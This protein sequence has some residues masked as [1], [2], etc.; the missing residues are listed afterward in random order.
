MMTM[1]NH[2]LRL[3]AVP[4][5]GLALVA[6]A[7]ATTL[8]APPVIIEG[9]R[10]QGVQPTLEES[11]QS[12]S[13]TPG[14][15]NVIDVAKGDRQQNTL[16]DALALQPGVMI[17]EFFGGNDQPRLNIRGSGIQ[18][19]PQARGIRLLRDGLPINLA[20]GS[21]VIGA[22][23]PRLA[24]HMEVYRG[25]NAVEYGGTALG[26]AINLV[27]PTGRTDPG[28]ALELSGGSFGQRLI[29]VSHGA[30]EGNRDYHI[31][32]TFSEADGFRRHNDSRRGVLGGNLG[33]AHADGGETRLYFE[34][35]DLEFDIPGP[36]NRAQLE[37]NPE[38]VNRGI[39]PT[40][41]P[42]RQAG[43]ESVG[44]N[45]LRDRPWRESRFTRA[46]VRTTTPTDAGRAEFGLGYQ[47]GDD[48][49]AS[50]TNVRESDSDDLSAQAAIEITDTG[51]GGTLN[52]GVDAALGEMTR[53]FSANEEGS[54]GRPFAKNDLTAVTTML[55]GDY[56]HPLAQHWT[57]VTAAQLIHAV[58]DVDEAF[59]TPGQR[60]RY[61][62]G[63][64]QY[65]QMQTDSAVERRQTYNGV[66]ARLGIL[67]EPG[68]H[69]AWFANLSQSYEPPTFLEILSPAGTDPTNSATPNIGP[70]V[71][72]A[73]PLDAQSAITFEAGTRGQWQDLSWDIAAYYSRLE[74]ELLTDEAFTGGFGTTSNYSDNTTR[75]GLELG[76][77]WRMADSLVQKGDQ[78]RF[79][80]AY[81]YSNFR[82]DGG[83]FDGNRIAGIPEHRLQ[84][85]LAYEQANGFSIAPKVLWLPSD[86]PTDHANT[87]KQESYALLG[88]RV[89]Y[90][91]GGA[92]SAYL[93]GENLTDR[94]Y[95]ASYLIRDR[96]PNPGP[97]NATP[98]Q[99]TSFL[100]GTGRT[101]NA[102]IRLEF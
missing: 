101:I 71:I 50:P 11:Q 44:P 14:G 31:T 7:S 41:P 10:I 40:P 2:L 34:H 67:F 16:S 74:D 12:L 15:V 47:H 68:D 99:V 87:I 48:T 70:G 33:F 55:F 93:Q 72:G 85:E 98:E 24:S 39:V 84:A 35:A 92:W 51:T 1:T 61:N 56:R 78:L 81:D 89:G 83:K 30:T 19:N 29:E 17:Q 22:L 18:S 60:P 9:E 8:E 32:G 52:V 69:T 90:D 66:N 26:G 49:F 54:V 28:T 65:E 37:E 63:A 76:L 96:V 46:A 45:V 4:L 43:S 62:A 42:K 73:A 38:Q 86:T 21:Y 3:G 82:F 27:S 6:T 97:P 57:L 25:A 80:N 88:L 94:P 13:R 95:A 64:G 102:G 20:D 91:P 23:E 36:L 58:R 75:E 53:E 5:T 59:A 79:Q 77:T 100:P